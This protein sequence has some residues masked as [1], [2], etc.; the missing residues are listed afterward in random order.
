MDMNL[1]FWSRSKRQIGFPI[2]QRSLGSSGVFRGPLASSWKRLEVLRG[3]GGSLGRSR[4]GVFGGRASV[5]LVAFKGTDWILHSADVI[6]VFWS[7]WRFFGQLLE[8]LGGPWG[9]W[10]VPPADLGGC[11]WW[12]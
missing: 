12:T 3:P 1:S 10:M 8:A 6:G 11:F 7:S 5:V 2:L 9:S 4:E